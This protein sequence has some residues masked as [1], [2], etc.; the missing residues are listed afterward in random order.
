MRLPAHRD[1]PV[2]P[3]PSRFSPRSGEAESPGRVNRRGAY[4]VGVD[5]AIEPEPP[6]PVR[7]AI[8]AAIAE[9][10]DERNSV[11][12]RAG[13]EDAVTDLRAQ[14]GRPRSNAGAA[15]A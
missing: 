14:A 10:D 4:A 5:V 8:L 12:W 6:E 11:W 15:R 13:I 7:R 1:L 3:S 2:D 9:V